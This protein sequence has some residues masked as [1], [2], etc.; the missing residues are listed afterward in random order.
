MRVSVSLGS[1][2]PVENP[3][4]GARFMIEQ[5]AAARGSSLDG[6]FVGD[7]HSNAPVSYY[8]NTP[9]MGRLLAE[10]GDAPAGILALI[11][12]WNPVLL[13]EHVATLAS[14][15]RGPFV[16]QA[17][18][19]RA[20][21]QYTAMGRDAR[22]RPSLFEEGLDIIRR[23]WAGETVSATHRFQFQD[24]HIAPL[25]PEPIEVWIGGSVSATIARA[26]RLGDGWLADPGLTPDQ[27][28]MQ[29]A[30]FLER[31]QVSGRA[32]SV[33]A[34]RKD[35]Y[36]GTSDEEAEGL[37]GPLLAKGH[38]G[39]DP[40]AVIYGSAETVAAKFRALADLG[41]TEVVTRSLLPD[42]AHALSSL[43]RLA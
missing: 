36:V 10:W 7:H 38:R 4:D 39:F 22:F 8:Q 2:Y 16:L 43:E 14:I 3:R 19:G 11:P 40:S 20:D 1:A 31:R 29:I 21:F 26:A 24:A 13:A 25:P 27:A 35:V 6:L 15:A 9:I 34:T 17:A 32:P 12:L 41:F 30:E 5:A 42:Q 18:V 37:C 33:V 28:S 23:L